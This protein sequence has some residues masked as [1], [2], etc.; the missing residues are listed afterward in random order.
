[1][2]FLLAALICTSAALELH[3]APQSVY[4]NEKKVF[5][6][7][8]DLSLVFYDDASQAELALLE[9]LYEVL[10]F[11]PKVVPASGFKPGGRA[12]Y[13]GV[14]GKHV[15]FEHRSLRGFAPDPAESGEQAYSLRV[16]N[17]GIMVAGAGQPGMIHGI[18]TLVQLLRASRKLGINRGGVPGV[19]YAEIQD[20]PDV[21]L[22]GACVRGPLTKDQI[23][24]FASLKCNMLIFESDDFYDMSKERLTLWQSVFEDARSVGITPVPVLQFFNVPEILLKRLPQAV[25]GRSRI[26]RLVLPDDDWAALTRRNIILTEENPFRIKMG[27]DALHFRQDYLVSEGS[28]VPPFDA[29][30]SQPWMIRR[31]AGS[32]VPP[33][34]TVEV[35]YS[36][37]PPGSNALCPSAPETVKLLQ[38]ALEPL[39]IGLQPEYIHCGFGDIG[40]INQ[41]LRC[42]EDGKT[43]AELFSSALALLQGA[44]AGFRPDTTVILWGD[45]MLPGTAPGQDT[46]SLYPALDNLSGRILFVPR[47]NED[48]FGATGKGKSVLDWMVERGTRPIAAISGSAPQCYSAVR[49]LA[50]KKEQRPGMILLNADPHSSRDSAALG[51]AWCAADPVL[52]W[53]EAMNRFFGSDLWDPDFSEMKEA[54]LGF[55]ERQFVSGI[56]PE[57][58]REQFEEYVDGLSSKESVPRD[59]IA[60]VEL[61][62]SQITRYME[63]EYE[64]SSGNEASAL[65]ELA[66][67]VRKSGEADITIEPE[68][69]EQIYQT[70]K[71]RELFVPSSILLGRPVAYYRPF[72]MP[73]GT[74]ACEA[75]ARVDYEDSEENAQATL[76]FLVSCGP[77]FRI[78]FESM[79]AVSVALYGSDDGTEF[80]RIEAKPVVTGTS[81][82]GPILLTTSVHKRYL[83]LI[84]ESAGEQA[85]LRE[86]RAFFLKEPA[87]ATVS[88]A[89]GADA[90]LLDPTGEHS[91]G[92]LFGERQR[93]AVAPTEIRID[94]NTR[95]LR[96]TIIARDPLPH[97]MSAVMTGVDAP[98]WEEESVELWIKPPRQL[99]RRFVVN[100]LGTRHDAIAVASNLDNWDPGWDGDWQVQAQT[101]PEGW[102]ASVK[103]PFALLGG[104]PEPG[105]TWRANFTRHRNSVEKETSIWSMD[106]Y[107]DLVFK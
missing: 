20:Y 90:Q 74:V 89:L 55:L 18:Q 58:V 57:Q 100:P 46:Q 28:L 25:E 71:E 65:R 70:V 14:A 93:L 64:Y 5:P 17:G 31:I 103:I 27:G 6:L 12:L 87:K 32:A 82:R 63:L 60:P 80:K 39:I 86:V 72:R 61:L 95:Y 34:T 35:T 54:V 91:V 38:T 42:R 50:A 85:V 83:R 36:Y 68:R 21:S 23:G 62:V 13:I 45:A 84:V 96:A 53:P 2:S 43:G 22:R 73:Q 104:A 105:E 107:G 51:K 81:L 48:A 15:A 75:P 41:D 29:K 102:T 99:A 88:L 11:K 16:S 40:R 24:A 92:M 106:G 66:G 101:D 56:P 3:P 76:D 78:D 26:D 37:A 59:E 67:L 10:D 44:I 98:L 97:A 8:S 47:F 79:H 94:G 9:P 7:E 1:M 19:P 77:I 49:Q 33:N 4:L 52:L 69:V 30:F